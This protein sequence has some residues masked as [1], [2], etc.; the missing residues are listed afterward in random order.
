MRQ[1]IFTLRE[2][3]MKH[4]SIISYSPTALQKV[5]NAIDVLANAEGLPSHADSVRLRMPDRQPGNEG[6]VSP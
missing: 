2:T 1:E 4:S 5:A 3:F 6:G